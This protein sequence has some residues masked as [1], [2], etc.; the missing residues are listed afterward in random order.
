MVD[1]LSKLSP[2][3]F[4]TDGRAIFDTSLLEL[5][6]NSLPG[7]YLAISCDGTFT[8]ERDRPNKTFVT[9]S[10]GN[11]YYANSWPQCSVVKINS[12]FHGKRWD[13][14]T[15]SYVYLKAPD[16]ST[17]E[18]VVELPALTKL[19]DTKI[20]SLPKGAIEVDIKTIKFRAVRTVRPYETNSIEL[21]AELKE[22]Q[23]MEQ[24]AFHLKERAEAALRKMI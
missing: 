4:E 9:K 23:T 8:Y 24:V 22:G 10:D 18:Y 13:N 1:S 11:F 2:V 5:V 17:K 7:A 6:D 3:D 14:N 19:M 15:E 16:F 21:T 20:H 12:R